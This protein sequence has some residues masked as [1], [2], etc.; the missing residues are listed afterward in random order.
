VRECLFYLLPC[1]ETSCMQL[2][3]GRMLI[4]ADGSYEVRRTESWRCLMKGI[5][6]A[7]GP[8]LMLPLSF[9]GSGRT[10]VSRKL[11]F[12]ILYMRSSSHNLAPF[13][14]SLR[15]F[16]TALCATR[17]GKIVAVRYLGIGR[18]GSRSWVGS[19]LI[20][21]A[22]RRSGRKSFP[23]ISVNKTHHFD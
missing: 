1:R 17:T 18:R 6:E 23:C 20:H 22:I 15:H 5:D 12:P 3:A 2:L 14:R 4:Y 10:T 19:S 8:P 9:L 16:S 21:V 13:N 7:N 11:R